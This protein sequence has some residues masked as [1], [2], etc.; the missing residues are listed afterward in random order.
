MKH[1][2]QIVPVMHIYVNSMTTTWTDSAA[3]WERILLSDILESNK[4]K[5]LATYWLRPI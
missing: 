2:L 5:T 3:T 1:L 4:Y